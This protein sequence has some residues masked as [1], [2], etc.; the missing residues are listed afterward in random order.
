MLAALYGSL[1]FCIDILKQAPVRDDHLYIFSGKTYSLKVTNILSVTLKLLYRTRPI[2]FLIGQTVRAGL[3][4][5]FDSLARPV[6]FVYHPD[7]ARL[8]IRFT[9]AAP[10]PF[11]SQQHY[12]K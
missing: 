7:L 1:H 2:I 9:F 11:R 10:G 3:F 4:D 5:F 8:K 6:H 12:E